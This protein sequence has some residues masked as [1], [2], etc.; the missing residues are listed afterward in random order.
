MNS[1]DIREF[2]IKYTNTDII[3]IPN[4]GNVGDT[5]IV[6]GTIQIF[7]ELNLRWSIGNINQVYTGKTLFYGGGG[8]LVGIY[9][10]AYWF[11][12][13]N[14][15][16]NN[17]VILPHTIKDENE[18]IKSFSRKI[19]V[20]CREMVSYNYVY[21]LHRYKKNVFLSKDMAFYINV[22]SE[23][24]NKQ[25]NGTGNC[26]RTDSETNGII[27]IPSD[28]NDISLTLLNEG[29]TSIISVIN[30]LTISFFEYISN[31]EIINTDRLH[32]AIAATLLNKK[33]NV[34]RN[35]YYKVQA[36]FD[37]SIKNNFTNTKLIE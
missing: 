15:D 13:K 20:I 28:N 25:G 22:P 27:D 31:Y 26:F 19:I 2:L 24:K 29:N 30:D 11:L 5:I 8:N 9:K 1:L 35:S 14:K 10:T 18:L 36:I 16:N 33:V 3:Y 21:N 34:Y 17:I 7:N 12:E 6:Y 23:L 32:V 37:F 4:P